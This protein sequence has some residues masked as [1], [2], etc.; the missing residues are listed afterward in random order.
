MSLT[1]LWETIQMKM[2]SLAVV[3]L[4]SA[5]LLRAADPEGF[6]LWKGDAVKNSGKELASK[7][8]DQK[9]AWQPLGTYGNHLMGFSHPEGDGSAELDE[10]QLEIWF[11][12]GG[13][14]SLIVDVAMVEAYTVETHAL[15]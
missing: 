10:T 2:L 11:V 12:E 13:D 9:F 6:A 5:T 1:Y 3:L 4:A 14:A 8:D 7:I 15:G